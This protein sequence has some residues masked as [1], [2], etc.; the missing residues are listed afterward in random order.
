MKSLLKSFL[1]PLFLITTA[2]TLLQAQNFDEGLRYYQQKK[3]EQAVSVFS[4]LK[5]NEGYLFAGKSFYALGQYPVAQ[6]NL[7][8]ISSDA[9][10]QLLD[11]ARYTSALINF[12]QKRFSNALSYLFELQQIYGSE[13]LGQK[14]GRLYTQLLN[15]L[16]GDQRFDA[17]QKIEQDEIKFDLFKTA[18]GKIDY[19]QAQQLYQQFEEQLSNDKWIDRAEEY[20]S[21]LSS[22]SAYQSE[23]GSSTSKLQPPDGTTYNI[24]VALP[25]YDTGDREFDIVKGMY[26]GAMIAAEEYNDDHASTQSYIHF[27]NTGTSNNGLR[28]MMENFSNNYYGDAIIGP[29]FS[30]QAKPMVSLSNDYRIPV[31]APLANSN[32]N[33]QNS[34]LFQSNP[35]YRMHGRQMARYAVNQLK[36]KRFAIMA[37]RETSGAVSAEAFRD[38]AE[39]LGAEIVHYFVE[40]LQ[41]NNYAVSQYTQYFGSKDDPLD[42]VYAPFTGRTALT[43]IDLL[44]NDM[45]VMENAIAL[46]GS[47]EWQNLDFK[48][49]KYRNLNIY[50]TE[51]SYQNRNS[52]RLARFKNEYERTFNS[53]GNKFSLIGYDISRFILETLDEVGNPDL[54]W[55]AI[56]HHSEYRGLIK[57]FR[58]EGGNVNTAVKILEVTDTGDLVTK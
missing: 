36:M 33:A 22:A 7:N 17:M 48:S 20:T 53:T 43:L 32:I 54:L 1:I 55:S 41:S 18:M 39:K 23:Y 4:D 47:Q 25:S 27:S 14:A 34:Y 45:R 29:L 2:G 30:E 42:A 57:D 35:T 9:P 28:T 37:N 52:G 5:S 50:F 19:P 31:M 24:S 16:S 38:E 56:A 26:L 13:E 40:D 49:N 51:G 11:E 6:A 44:L 58:F 10:R 12:Q 15:Y 21:S 3:Y 8:N 46:L